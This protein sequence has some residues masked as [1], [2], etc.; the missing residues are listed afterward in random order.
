M[1]NRKTRSAMRRMLFTL[2]LVLVVAVASV[3]GT[4]AWLRVETEPVTNTF[5]VGNIGLTLSETTRTYKIVPGVSIP[6]DPKVTV[7]ANSEK[8]YVFLK[9]VE[10]NW[11]T[12]T[13]TGENNAIIRKVNYTITNDWALYSTEVGSDAKTI[14]KVYYKVVDNQATAKELQVLV[15]NQVTVAD[16]LTKA[17]VDDITIQPTLT[18][19]AYAVQYE[20]MTSVDDAWAKAQTATN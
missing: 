5:T 15:G 9:V 17:E 8:C 16:S 20:G 13:Y 4:L 14:T 7:A 1:K 3:G 2:A 18:F 19:T 12:P 10:S 11:P 6:K